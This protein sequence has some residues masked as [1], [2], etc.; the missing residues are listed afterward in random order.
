MQ[1]NVFYRLPDSVSDVGFDNEDAENEYCR[2]SN[3]KDVQTVQL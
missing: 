1:T 2:Q 3:S